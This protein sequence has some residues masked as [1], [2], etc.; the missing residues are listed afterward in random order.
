MT[1]IADRQQG[2]ERQDMGGKLPLVFW[3]TKLSTDTVPARCFPTAT[4]I[5]ASVNVSLLP[6]PPAQKCPGIQRNNKQ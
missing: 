6:K 2:T 4:C 3:R 5:N 1:A